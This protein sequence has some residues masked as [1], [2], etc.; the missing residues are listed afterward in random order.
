MTRLDKVDMCLN[1]TFQTLLVNKYKRNKSKLKFVRMVSCDSF[2]MLLYSYFT[3]IS[4][5]VL[6]G[7]SLHL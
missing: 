1:A 4:A 3:V 7:N 2:Y 5:A 6:S